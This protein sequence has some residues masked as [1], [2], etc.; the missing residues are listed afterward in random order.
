MIVMAHEPLDH[1]PS[2][3]QPE[4]HIRPEAFLLEKAV[5]T[6]KFAVALG[7]AGTGADVGHPDLLDEF[8]EA[9]GDELGP[10]IGDDRRIG[11]WREV[12][13]SLQDRFHVGQNERAVLFAVEMISPLVRRD[14]WGF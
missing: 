13:G 1:R 5:P 6:F 11:V 7:I 14:S 10:V 9:L 3:V 8:L 12:L 2:V 4:W